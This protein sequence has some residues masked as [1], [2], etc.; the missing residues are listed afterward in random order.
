MNGTNEFFNEDGKSRLNEPGSVKGLQFLIDLYKKGYAPKD[1]VN[2]GFNEIVAGFY[3]G[4]CAFLDQDPDALIAI[5]ERMPAEDFAR[6]HRCRRARTARPSRPS[7]LPAGRCS[8]STENKDAAWKLIA[9]LSSPEGQRRPGTSGS[10]CSRSTRA[11][12]GPVLQDRAV[13]GLVRGAQRPGLR[14]DRHADLSRGVRLLHGSHDP[15]GP[16]QEALLG[17]K[18]AQELATSGPTS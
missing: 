14:A 13:Q 3:S 5:A 18:T 17:Q 7:A 8:T 16:A 9:T 2:W 12:T 1:S 4:T 10:A 6:H 11:P 15:E